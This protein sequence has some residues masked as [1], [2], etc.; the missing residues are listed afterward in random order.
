MLCEQL[1][2]DEPS[3]SSTMWL[4]MFCLDEFVCD[5]WLFFSEWGVVFGCVVC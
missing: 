2:I 4:R 1:S 5:V 3:I